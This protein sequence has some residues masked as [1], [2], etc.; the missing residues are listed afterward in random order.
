MAASQRRR[1]SG[2]GTEGASPRIR[3]S[4]RDSGY[5][6]SQ[7]ACV[8]RRENASR[9]VRLVKRCLRLVTIAEYRGGCHSRNLHGRNTGYQL[10]GT[11]LFAERFL[12]KDRPW[13]CVE[14]RAFMFSGSIVK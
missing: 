13:K 4:L 5:G 1:Q 12:G 9:E 2:I 3:L 14:S 10:D 8:K 7:I 11:C 6:A